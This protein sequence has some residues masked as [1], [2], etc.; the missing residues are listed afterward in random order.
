MA[1]I[2]FCFTFA[3]ELIPI[4]GADFLIEVRIHYIHY[5]SSSHFTQAVVNAFK[6]SW[7]EAGLKLYKYTCPK[8]SAVKG[9]EKNV[10]LLKRGTESE[11]V[12]PDLFL[13]ITKSTA[14][15]IILIGCYTYELEI[16]SRCLYQT[17]PWT[18]LFKSWGRVENICAFS[19]SWWQDLIV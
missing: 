13:G 14:K 5:I 7:L 9:N 19:R 16:Y 1:I 17:F 11:F 3:N 12:V 6:S 15:G 4:I 8:H 2:L 10:S 18:P